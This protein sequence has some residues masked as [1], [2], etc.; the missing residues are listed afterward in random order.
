LARSYRA[1]PRET[2]STLILTGGEHLREIDMVLTREATIS[3]R[4]LDEDGD[5]VANLTV[6]QPFDGAL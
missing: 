5:H 3:G 4:V 1:K 6:R 2:F